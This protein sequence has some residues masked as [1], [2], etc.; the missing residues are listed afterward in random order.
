MNTTIFTA[1]DEQAGIWTSIAS[2]CASLVAG[3]ACVGPMLGIVLGVSGL[4]W[5]TRYHYLTL[6]ATIASLVLLAVA[7]YMY[8]RRR[9]SCINRRKHQL[10]VI[11]L[12][13]ITAIVVGISVFEYLIF[14]NMI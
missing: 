13:A 10:N 14:P 8:K 5:L 2:L 6:P 1:K 4:G 11:L 3:I 7:L 9:T 12:G